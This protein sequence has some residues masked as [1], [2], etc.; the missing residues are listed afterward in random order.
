M[1]LFITPLFCLSVCFF[2]TTPRAEDSKELNSLRNAKVIFCIFD[3]TIRT[4]LADGKLIPRESKEKHEMVFDSIDFFSGK[5]R[6]VSTG[7]SIST[8]FTAGGATLFEGQ[9]FDNHSF[10]TIF[11]VTSTNNGE[12]IAVHSVHALIPGI[13][14]KTGENFYVPAQ[15][16]GSCKVR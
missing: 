4:D 6:L 11:P 15:R 5:A 1:R 2:S 14:L 10:T 13:K 8:F 12:F 9:G 16:Y 7:S 3:R